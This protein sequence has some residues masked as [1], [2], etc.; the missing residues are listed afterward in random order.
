[1]RTLEVELPDE[2]ARD[3]ERAIATGRFESSGELVR[4][5]L[6]DFLTSRRFELL[7]Q[8]QLEDV[9]WALREK[10]K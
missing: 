10:S 6:R 3:L 4:A 8:Q 5:A 9:S 7:E 2:L 1:M